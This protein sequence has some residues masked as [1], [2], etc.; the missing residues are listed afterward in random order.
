M[1]KWHL[2]DG[3]LG[4]SENVM[5]NFMVVT[6]GRS[7][8]QLDIYS[9]GNLAMI[10]STDSKSAHPSPTF[11]TWSQGSRLLSWLPHFLYFRIHSTGSSD[12]LM[13]TL[14]YLLAPIYICMYHRYLESKKPSFEF[15]ILDPR[16]L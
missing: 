13:S 16:S 6:Y 2:N 4:P 8:I 1:S 5:K 7:S 15:G 11:N 3:R 9:F 12:S 14:S 10:R